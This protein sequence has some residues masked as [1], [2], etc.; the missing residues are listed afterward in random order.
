MMWHANF[1]LS[2][3]LSAVEHWLCEFLIVGVCKF[4]CT[5]ALLM[6][7]FSLWID[8]KED[9][10]Y[11]VKYLENLKK[12]DFVEIGV[13]LGIDY[14]RLDRLSE[15]N[16]PHE[17][18]RLWLLKMDLVEKSGIPTLNSLMRALRAKGF[19]GHADKISQSTSKTC[20]HI[21]FTIQ[22]LCIKT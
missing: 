13:E 12:Q 1:W 8:C 3:D 7:A 14:N 15:H 18:I 9:L 20:F 22:N 2:F 11:I 21:M 19:T 5:R 6:I 17:M 10:S 16:F 4:D